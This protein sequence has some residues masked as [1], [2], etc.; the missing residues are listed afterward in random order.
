MF[1]TEFEEQTILKGIKNCYVTVKN[2]NYCVI[3]L[4]TLNS[5]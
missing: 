3:N 4:Y 1:I 2:L 5:L